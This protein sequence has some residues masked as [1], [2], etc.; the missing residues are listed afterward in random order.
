MTAGERLREML[1]AGTVLQVPAVYDGLTARLAAQAGF[2]AITITGNALAGSLLGTPDVGLVTM[3][4]VAGAA[5]NIASAVDV[6]VL[7]DADT[8]YGGVLNVIRTVRE[9]ESAGLA[10]IHLEDQVTPKRCGLVDLPIPVVSTDEFQ[11]KLAAAVSARRHPSF[12]IIARTDAMSTLGLDEAIR[13]ANAY[14]D[15]GADMA[16]VIGPRTVDEL[17]RCGH[18][19]RGP[20]VAVIDERGA[21]GEL[22][23]RELTELKVAMAIYAGVARYAVINAVRETLAALR[24]DGHSRDY[25]DRLASLD[26][27]NQVVGFDAYVALE[28]RFQGPFAEGRK[29]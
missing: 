12:M 3:A 8:G 28:R 2:G 16:M 18:G 14:L 4:E 22:A 25:R 20:L 21:T 26:D 5:R 15:A 29:S 9:L 11:A 10:G 23:A 6:P 17:R 13:R 27:Y 7:C 19:V 1:A 24:R